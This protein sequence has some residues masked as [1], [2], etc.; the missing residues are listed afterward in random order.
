MHM[1]NEDHD[2]DALF[3]TFL[4]LRCTMIDDVLIN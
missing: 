1:M 4:V 3:Y 2:K